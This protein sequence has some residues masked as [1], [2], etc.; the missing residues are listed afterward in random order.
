MTIYN[1][2]TK[3]AF[4]VDAREIAPLKASKDM[5]AGNYEG[6]LFGPLASGVPGEIQGYWM[7]HEKF[8]RL[9]WARLFRRV[10]L[11]AKKGWK[12]SA[13]AAH[14]LESLVAKNE[15]QLE[16]LRPLLYDSAK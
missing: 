14:A 15:T 12:L 13:S 16:S 8:G 2:T 11:M 7:A 9:P 4:I 1:R 3:K 6:S 5:Y 10:I